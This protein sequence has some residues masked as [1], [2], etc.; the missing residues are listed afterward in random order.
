MQIDVS[1]IGA[2]L[3]IEMGSRDGARQSLAPLADTLVKLR[4]PE[5][6]G[7][8]TIAASFRGAPKARTRNPYGLACCQGFRA[9]RA[10]SRNDRA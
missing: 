5:P 2:L 1:L 4:V 9:R 7:V 8:E 3:V 10:A 6:T